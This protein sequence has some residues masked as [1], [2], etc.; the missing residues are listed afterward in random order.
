MNLMVIAGAS[1]PC[2]AGDLGEV[3]LNH[4]FIPI[5]LDHPHN[6]ALTDVGTYPVRLIARLPEDLVSKSGLFLPLLESWVSEG[7]SLAAG[8]G[9]LFDRKAASITRSKLAISKM[10]DAA[11]IDSVPRFF[12][13]TVQ[14]AIRAA[15]NF[16][17]PAVIRPDTGYSSHGV[18]IAA[19]EDELR[20][21]WSCQSDERGQGNYS[22]MRL[23][24]DEEGDRLIIEPWLPGEEW[25]VD[26]AVGPAGTFPIRVCRKATAIQAGRPV[27]LGY[28]LI[29]KNGLWHELCQA[30]MDWTSALF[31]AGAVSFACFDIRRQPN[32]KLVP[33]DFGS[34]LGGDQIPLLVRNAGLR[35]N[36]YAAALDSALGGE[37]CQDWV[38]Q[39]GHAIVHAITPRTGTFNEIRLVRPGR[40]INSKPRGFCI[41]GREN[42]DRVRRVGTVLTHF[43]TDSS[44][45]EACKNATDW[46]KI[47]MN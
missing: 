44:F 23:M 20:A 10:L 28:R 41:E 16:G 15:S 37:S 4:G 33:L 12:V 2:G 42:L 34:R 46:I 8:S 6:A 11:G 32:G 36:P 21:C 31:M 40:V 13:E 19:T 35:G 14:Q 43:D 22:E 3:A 27:T 38:A 17:Y 1:F 29:E 9:L 24:M 5:F 30:V 25:S 7:R 18:F 39:A 45:L 47:D 26:C